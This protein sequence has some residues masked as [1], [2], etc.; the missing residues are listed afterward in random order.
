MLE[1]EQLLKAKKREIDHLEVP[2]ELEIRLRNTLHERGGKPRV[3]NWKLNLAAV[4][5]VVLLIGYNFDALAYYGKQLMGYD[6]LMN[7]T[8]SQLNERGE[9][10]AVGK[11]YHFKNGVTLTLSGIMLDQNQLLAF[12]TVADPKGDIDKINLEPSMSLAG[13]FNEYHM[14]SG[15]GVMN[16]QKT[17]IKNIAS[18]ETPHFYERTLSLNFDLVENGTNE[19]GS[20]S[21]RLD[22]NKAMGYTLK[23]VL[24]KTVK[25]DDKTNISLKSILA[26]PTKTVV[27]GSVQNLM[28]LAM[29]QVKGERVKPYDLDLKLIANNKVVS[30]QG[31]GMS[32]DLNGITF[33]HDYDALPND[34]KRL[35]IKL[36]SF[37]ADHDVNRQLELSKDAPETSMQVLG[38]N[39]KIDRLLETGGDTFITITS[40]DQILLTRVFLMMDGKRVDLKETTADNYVKQTDGTIYHTRTLHFPG[41]GDKLQLI[42]QRIRFPITA[43]KVI[44]IPID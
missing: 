21:F 4:F 24:N 8:L 39:I 1:I 41:T 34:L 18:F 20:I 10:Q 7:G 6:Q 22:R 11:S 31:G 16:D 27:E 15:S 12:Y 42:V 35:Q 33:H 3:Y 30:E 44:E 2:E 19:R 40:K 14:N 28:E 26:T 9:G 37:V 13:W 25:L 32:S 36:V 17:E 38:Q 29:D 5:V 23:R 43:D